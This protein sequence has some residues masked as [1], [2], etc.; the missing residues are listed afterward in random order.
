MY[1]L[2][3]IMDTQTE[4]ISGVYVT[5]RVPEPVKQTLQELAKSERRTLSNYCAM[6][7]EK[8]L[9]ANLRNSAASPDSLQGTLPSIS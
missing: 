2:V 1:T 9:E 4:E 3:S 8:A 6:L 5:I 7:L